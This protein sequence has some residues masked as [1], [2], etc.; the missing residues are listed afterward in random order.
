[1]E[2]QNHSFREFILSV[3]SLMAASNLYLVNLKIKSHNER[4]MSVYL[5]LKYGDL[6]SSHSGGYPNSA[7]A[8]RVEA[9]VFY[10]LKKGGGNHIS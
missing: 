4:Q 1:M 5:Q 7:P 2:L 10:E 6:G 3:V 8:S 9:R